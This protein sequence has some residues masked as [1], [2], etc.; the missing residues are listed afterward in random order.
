VIAPALLQLAAGLSG[1]RSA[2]EG[3]LALFG[4]LAL[5]DPWFLLL[6]PLVALSLWRGRSARRAARARIPILPGSRP[7][8]SLAQRLAWLA[9]TLQAAGLCLGVL[10]LARPLRGNVQT[11]SISEGVD[12]AI[13]I[14]RSSSMGQKDMEGDRTRLDV[15]KQVVEDFA[16]RRMTDRE[17]NAD[18]IGLIGF[19]RYPQQVCPFTLDVDSVR[20]FLRE[21]QMVST[22]PEDGT[23]IGIAL[24]KAVAVLRETEARSKVC[25]L[26]TDGENNL[27]LITPMQGA[28]LAAEIGVRVYTIFAGRYVRDR[29]GRTFEVEKHVDMSEM[30]SIAELTGGRFFLARDRAGLE[31][32][33]AEIERLERTERR[34][35]RVIEHFDLYPPLLA[36]ALS[37]YA[38]AWLFATTFARRLP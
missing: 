14:D 38:A 34:E 27:D 16:V 21:L 19:A 32:A 35:R 12:I 8:A 20:G 3:R 9:P 15:V 23:G 13:L 30:R 17:G 36:G 28:E 31:A 5:A 24:A 29:L 18:N 1:E 22:P 25:I 2:A 33:Y 10:A 26:L 6:L 4:D 7:P 11:D 37:L